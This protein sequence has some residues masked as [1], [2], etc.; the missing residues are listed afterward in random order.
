MFFNKCINLKLAIQFGYLGKIRPYARKKFYNMMKK[1]FKFISENY[2]D[3]VVLESSYYDRYKLI[4]S[5]P[6]ELY[7]P[8]YKCQK[9]IRIFKATI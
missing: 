2:G 6:Y 7:K 9:T 4:K 1:T 3:E 5:L 8:V